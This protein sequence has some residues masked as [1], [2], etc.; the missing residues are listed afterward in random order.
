MKQGFTAANSYALALYTLAFIVGEISHFMIGV[1]TRDVARDIG[2][3]DFACYAKEDN[4]SMQ[5]NCSDFKNQQICEALPYCE[6]LRNGQGYD[7][8]ILAGPTFVAV[9]T[10]SGIIMGYLAD[11]VPRPQLLAICVLLFSTCGSL[12]GIAT[13]YWHLVILRMG[14]AAGEAACRPSSGSLIAEMFDTSTRG[15]AN[16]IFSW[17]V[18]IGYGLTFTLGNYLA[19][20]DLLGFGWRAAFVV[21]CA[22][23]VIVALFLFFLKDPRSKIAALDGEDKPSTEEKSGAKEE[24]KK[25]RRRSVIKRQEKQY[26]KTLFYALIQPTMIL[27]FV[28]AAFRH[29]GGYTWA[30]NTQVYLQQYYPEY[31]PGLWLTMCSIF[32]G[33][34][35]VFFGGLLSDIVVKKLGLHSRLWILSLSTLI[36]APLAVGVL[37]VEP[38]YA[39]LFLL[40][41]YFFAETWFAV[42]FTVLVEIVPAEVRSVSIAVFLFL[43]NNVGGNLPVLSQ[44]VTEKFDDLRKSLFIFWPGFVAASGIL[45][46]VSSI[47]LWTASKNPKDNNNTK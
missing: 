10:V 30:Y 45:F 25:G 8:L 9:F 47:P 36:A 13:E 33:S 2:Y 40:A 4:S 18:Y 46:F 27:L 17:G 11:K 21:G 28:A 32:G 20:A 15:V 22:P 34:F 3:G 12:I 35:G 39:F 16:G 41:Y 31:N 42:L 38:P 23:G 6:Y 19:P 7:Y 1:L 43:M 37:S 29:T 44:L 5:S 14:I 24:I 26:F